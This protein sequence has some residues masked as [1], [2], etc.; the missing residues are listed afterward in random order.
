MHHKLRRV[1]LA[2]VALAPLFG[3]GPV[4]VGTSADREGDARDPGKAV[5]DFAAALRLKLETATSGDVIKVPEGV[6]SFDRGLS[7]TTDGVTIRGAG[8]DRSVL[9]FKGQIAGAEGLLVTASDFTIEDLAIEDTVGDALKI[10]GGRNITVRGVRT[11]WNGGPNPDN[12]AYGI[13]PVQTENTLVENSVAVGASDA[14]IYVGQSRNV[15]VRN[16]RAEFNVAGIEIE[17]T[18]HAD[19]HGNVAVNNTGGILVFNMPDL[20]QR[21]HSTRIFDNQVANNNTA[22]FGAPGSAVAGVPAGSG[23]LINANDLIEVF[24]NEVANN[25]TANVLISSYFSAD[26][27]AD[28]EVV[29]VFDPYPETIFIHDNAFG[30]GGDKPDHEGLETVRTALYGAEGRLPDIV[31]DGVSHPE[32]TGAEHAICVNNP[33]AELLNIDGGNGYANP[34]V[35]SDAHSCTHPNL[36]PVVLPEA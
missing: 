32:R 9:N 28:R 11:A 6:F 26:Y 18:V 16:N 35:G 17:N 14:G 19:V 36:E 8:A 12:G 22:N 34:S 2:L 21:G 23:I 4:G 29:D 15:V 1:S 30:G 10:K 24:G 7:L 31:W 5:E 33:P 13:Y 3:C 27:S 20:P 25:Q